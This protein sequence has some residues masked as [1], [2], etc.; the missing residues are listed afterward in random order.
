VS[1]EQDI[2]VLVLQGKVVVSCFL[3]LECGTN[4]RPR[5]ARYGGAEGSGE[6]RREANIDGVDCTTTTLIQTI[7]LAFCLKNPISILDL[8]SKEH[9]HI[10]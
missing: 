4:C 7:D 10:Y 3:A 1:I 8:F 2:P 6:C 5:S 9:K